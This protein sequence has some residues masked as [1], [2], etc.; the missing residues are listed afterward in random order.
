MIYNYEKSKKEDNELPDMIEFIISNY[1]IRK[2]EN[3]NNMISVLKEDIVKRKNTLDVEE[4]GFML[5]GLQK[6]QI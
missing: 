6:S 1:R 3:R 4:L 5:E 2:K